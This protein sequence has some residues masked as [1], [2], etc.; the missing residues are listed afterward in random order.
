MVVGTIH[1]WYLFQK[2]EKDNNGCDEDVLER[3]GPL[4]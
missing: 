3:G 2:E 1:D 4:P